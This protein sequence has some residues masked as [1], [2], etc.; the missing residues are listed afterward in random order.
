MP[1]RPVKPW[2]IPR[3][4]RPLSRREVASAQRKRSGPPHAHCRY[5]ALGIEQLASQATVSSA[6]SGRNANVR[7]CRLCLMGTNLVV[8]P[9]CSATS[10]PMMTGQ[11]MSSLALIT[12]AGQV[13]TPS[14]SVNPV[15]D[16]VASP[17]GP[18]SSEAVACQRVTKSAASSGLRWRTR[19]PAYRFQSGALPG[20]TRAPRL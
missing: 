6:T 7:Q 16:A 8:P 5:A 18:N 20:T 4:R 12:S 15:R 17:N 9:R 19:R 11:W 10:L 1:A 14:Y 3:P 2:M 13:M